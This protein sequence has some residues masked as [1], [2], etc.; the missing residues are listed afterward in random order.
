MDVNVNFNLKYKHK[1]IDTLWIK[2]KFCVFI[3][4]LSLVIILVG[5]FTLSNSHPRVF[6]WLDK[7][8]IY[9]AIYISA[10]VIIICPIIFLRKNVNR[11]L[12]GE[13]NIKM[14]FDE[15]D[16]KY[17]YSLNTT[18]KNEIYTEKGEIN[19]LNKTGKY[20][21]LSTLNKGRS[22]Y[23]PLRLLSKDKQTELLNLATEIKNF[24]TKK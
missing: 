6:Y 19:M 3:F 17:K 24:R 5:I 23:I 4:V 15:D 14:Y 21:E 18:K 8:K 9:S 16:N 10:F 12:S 22:Y 11:G 20:I 7:L 13:M 2:L 1:F